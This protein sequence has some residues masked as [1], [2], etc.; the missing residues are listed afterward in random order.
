MCG[1]AN[2]IDT[3]R[4]SSATETHF[5]QRWILSIQRPSPENDNNSDNKTQT[6]THPTKFKTHNI[7]Q[8][9]GERTQVADGP[10]RPTPHTDANNDQWTPSSPV[11]SQSSVSSVQARNAH[12]A[13]MRTASTTPFSGLLSVSDE[14]LPRRAAGASVRRR[15]GRLAGRWH[16]RSATTAA[17]AAAAARYAH[18]ATTWT[19]D[20][21]RGG[22]A[23]RPTNQHVNC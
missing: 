6:H 8:A 13:R 23:R 19:T 18:A 16:H 9:R 21:I 17:H 15:Q 7:R 12:S 20:T 4:A 2:K 5:R 14:R 10:T 22:W 3:P 11:V 1:D